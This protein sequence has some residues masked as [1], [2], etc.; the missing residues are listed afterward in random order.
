MG[1]RA[2][3]MLSFALG[4][5]LLSALLAGSTFALIRSNQLDRMEGLVRTQAYSNAEQLQDRIDASAESI[6]E[7]VRGLPTPRDG[8]PQLFMPN[9]PNPIVKVAT[10]SEPPPIELRTW[11][12][13]GNTGMMTYD[14]SG[15]TLVAVGIAIPTATGEVAEYY[16]PVPLTD[17][18][19]N[20][21]QLAIALLGAGVLTTL[22][23]AAVGR[24]ASR[25]V[26]AP[27]A[28]VSRAAEAIA[29]DQLETRLPT[30]DADP[31]LD[32]L[33]RSFNN[34]AEKL[35]DRI[36]RDAR[37]A[38]DVSHELRSPLMTLAASIEVLEKRRDDMPDRAQTALDLLSEDVVRFQQL[39][40][41]LLEISRFDAGAQHLDVGPLMVGEFVEAVVRHTT[42]PP[43]PVEMSLGMDSLIVLA[44]R[45]RLGQI[46]SNLLEN[47]RKYGNGATKVT[48]S[49]PEH[50]YIDEVEIVVEDEGPGVPVE[51]REI[52]FDR[53][54]RGS[55]SGRRGSDSGTG[56]GLSLVREH[57]ALHGGR[58]WVEEHADGRSGARFVVRLPTRA[59]EIDAFEDEPAPDL[60]DASGEELTVEAI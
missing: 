17:I 26:L 13:A 47:A 34:M 37:F 48:V 10:G 55:G 19:D 57:A 18:E 16:E 36:E 28:S 24:W 2:R 22:A 4:S 20:L 5:M 9:D 56:L 43:V 1:L 49:H 40:E 42:D 50:G 32:G 45:R 60:A 33:V 31:D 12:N 39:V 15:S 14:Q 11:V 59:D 23:G 3:I 25:R 54:S 8:R 38:S 46:V 58:I 30:I 27:L 7:A 41:D 29:G 52:I 35:Q 44:D 6:A 53:F 21:E 51:E